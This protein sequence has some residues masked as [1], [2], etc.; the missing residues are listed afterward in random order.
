MNC[1]DW[2]I[3]IAGD[4]ESRE[5]REHLKQCASCREFAA[6]IG[7]NRQE[8]RR[9]SV[10]PVAVDALHQRVMAGIGDARRRRWPAWIWAA[11]A[12]ASLAALAVSLTWRRSL[13]PAPPRPVEFAI[14]PPATRAH[15]S[16]VT[17]QTH[18]QHR[19]ARMVA[20]AGRPASSTEPLVVK[21]LTDDPNVVII[22]I[23]DQK[24]DS[25]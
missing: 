23:A 12:A 10:D 13:D 5:V 1:L 16:A 8:L 9:L 19:P 18:A 3:E 21:M 25:L 7:S 15:E 22:W 11:A 4:S 14:A 2:E 24:G 17:T 6:E 20:R